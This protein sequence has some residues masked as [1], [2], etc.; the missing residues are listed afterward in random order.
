[1]ATTFPETRFIMLASDGRHSTVSRFYPNDGEIPMME[2]SLRQQGLVGYL[3]RL[4]GTYHSKAA[5]VRVVGLRPLAGATAPS[6]DP[7]AID[8]HSPWVRACAGF[9]AERA[10]LYPK[11]PTLRDWQGEG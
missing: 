1:M 6:N 5:A 4:E 11:A 2:K 8:P 7:D 10:R 9:Q 3:C